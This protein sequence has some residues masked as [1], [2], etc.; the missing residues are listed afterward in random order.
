MN[1]IA[2]SHHEDLQ[3]YSC[4]CEGHRPASAFALW[5]VDRS[6]PAGHLA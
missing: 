1:Q 4:C 2:L 3:T 5:S 6:G